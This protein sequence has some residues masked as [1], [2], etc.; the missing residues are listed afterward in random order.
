MVDLTGYT[1]AIQVADTVIAEVAPNLTPTVRTDVTAGEIVWDTCDLLQV[2]LMRF[3]VTQ[4]YPLD[5]QQALDPRPGELFTVSFQAQV[6]RCWPSEEG[7]TL[8]PHASLIAADG[9]Q[10][11]T[12]V[13]CATDKLE[14][15]FSIVQHSV[16]PLVF[17]PPLGGLIACTIDFMVS[18]VR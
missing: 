5:D 2:S 16:Q 10:L 15:M 7:V 6:I 1:G 12:G 18:M 4:N 13:I 3:G 8:R 9:Y 14:S 11:Q 17:L